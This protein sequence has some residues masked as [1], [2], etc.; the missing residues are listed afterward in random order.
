MEC[1][2]CGAQTEPTGNICDACGQPLGVTADRVVR[3]TKRPNPLLLESPWGPRLLHLLLGLVAIAFLLRYAASRMG[4]VEGQSVTLSPVTIEAP[5]PD[6]PMPQPPAKEALPRGELIRPVAVSLPSPPVLKLAFGSRDE[7]VRDL[8]VRRNGGGRDTEEA[9]KRGLEW[10]K[11][12]QRPDGS[13]DCGALGGRPEFTLGVSGLSL[14]AFLGAGH[15]HEIEGPFQQTVDKAVA[16]L[17]ASQG[18]DGRFPGRLYHQGICTMALVEALG[19]SGDTSLELPSQRA[20]DA[21]VAA[22]QECGGWDYGFATGTGRGD[23]SVTGWQVMALKSAK[24]VG[25]DFPETVLPRAR[26]FLDEM[27]RAK[28]GAIAYDT[29]RLWERDD[30]SLSAMTAAGLNAHLFADAEH[31]E[32]N[33]KKGVAF[34]LH[35]PPV[36]PRFADGN[37]RPPA[38][39]Y[40]WYHAALALSRIGGHEWRFW[41]AR[42][43]RVLLELQNEHDGSW[44]PHGDRWARHG[45]GKIYVT[46][47]AILSLEVYYRYD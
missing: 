11:R 1:P 31:D 8:F 47:L 34:L 13:W 10:L 20:V 42:L 6:F 25:I 35:Y 39:M 17:L 3:T 41:N 32:R 30:Y 21:I 15:H 22:Q 46:A 24:R 27:T 26:E 23:T 43:K 4:G 44:D 29:K 36:L 33:I 38:N 19:M 28:D 7:R 12:N 14:L 18:E 40:L 5:E 2:H 37:W 45:G 9:V 16:Y